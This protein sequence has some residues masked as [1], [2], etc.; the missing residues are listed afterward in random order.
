MFDS[1]FSRL[2]GAW[3]LACL[4]LPVLAGAEPVEPAV[5]LVDVAE[6]RGLVFTHE[7]GRDAIRYVPE[8]TGSGVCVFDFDD[9]G[10]DDVY[11]VS[12]GRPG[13]YGAAEADADAKPRQP[14]RLFANDGGRFRDV[15]SGSGLEGSGWGMGCAVADVDGDSDL[16]LLVTNLGPD[17][18]FLNEGGGRFREVGAKAGLADPR[19]TTGAAFGDLEGDGDLDLHVVAYVAF[20]PDERWCPGPK[21]LTIVCGPKEYDAAPNRLYRNDGP[22]EDGLPRFVDVTATAGVEDASGKSLGVLFEDLDDD[23]RADLFVANDTERNSLFLN[24]G[25][26]RFLDRTLR[27]G[28]GFSAEGKTEAG[29]GLEA[30]DFN[31][32]GVVDLVV[33]NF[34]GETNTFYR[35]MNGGRWI[36]DSQ[37]SGVWRAT[38]PL[39]GFG[40]TAVDLELDGDLDLYFANGHVLHDISRYDETARFAQPDQVLVNRGHGRRSRFDDRSSTALRAPERVGRGSAW[41]DIEGDGDLDLVVNNCGGRAFLLENRSAR[42]GRHWLGVRLSGPAPNTSGLGARV[43]IETGPAEAP[44]R[45]ERRIRTAASYLSASPARAQFGLGTA[46]SAR[47]TVH[48]PDGVVQDVGELP[49]G[50]IHVVRRPEPTPVTTPARSP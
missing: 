16:D 46:S 25:E 13:D 4:H 36:D 26:G 33:T 18:L 34:Q 43:V 2:S 27:A 39:L 23:G 47:I 15:T 41:L 21:G 30:G 29:M 49:A 48:W 38:M 7:L 3:L 28:V 17:E 24:R 1:S 20:T 40:V 6:E 45:Q 42:A 44:L 9:D 37:S 19:W 35:G 10:D 11:L 12:G 8:T 5:L 22:G 31:G 14:S 32:D 50:A